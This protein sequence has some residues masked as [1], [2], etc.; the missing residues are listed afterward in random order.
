MQ[1]WFLSNGSYSLKNCHNPF[2]K[3]FQPPRPYGKILVEHLKSLHGAS[4][5]HAC[6]FCNNNDCMNEP[7]PFVKRW[8]RWKL[9]W[10]SNWTRS[11]YKYVV[12]SQP[13]LRSHIICGTLSNQCTDANTIWCKIM[14]IFIVQVTA[15]FIAESVSTHKGVGSFL[16]LGNNS[17]L[18][19]NFSRDAKTLLSKSKLHSIL[20]FA[21]FLPHNYFSDRK[22]SPSCGRDSSS[23]RGLPGSIWLR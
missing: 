21:F 14:S 18:S 23:P 8:T 4:L 20:T 1:I 22:G 11:S 2:G 13:K 9:H 19:F 6:L 5:M 15:I 17:F 16:S 10:G 3:G 7:L 12:Q